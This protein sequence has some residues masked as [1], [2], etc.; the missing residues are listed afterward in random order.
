MV[1]KIGGEMDVVKREEEPR[2]NEQQGLNEA[3]AI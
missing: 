1:W 2:D 3:K